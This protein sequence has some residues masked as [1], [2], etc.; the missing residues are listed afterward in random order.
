MGFYARTAVVAVCVLASA[1]VTGFSRRCRRRC[2]PDAAGADEPAVVRPGRQTKAR[3]QN[4]DVAILGDYAFV[5]G[6]SKN[7]GALSTPGRIC[8]DYGG[9]KVVEHR[10]SRC[11]DGRRQIDIADTKTILTGPKGNPRRTANV[12]N[13]SST[14]SSVD[15]FHNPVTNKDI[16]AIT[17]ERCEQSFFDGARI[18]FWDVTN[19]NGIPSTPIGVMDP[20]NIINPACIPGPCP[21]NTPADG[22]WGIFEDIRMFSRNNGPGGSTKVYAIATSPFSIG[23]TGGVS[24]V[25][26]FRLLDVTNPANPS[27]SRASPTRRSGRARTTAAAPSRPRAPRRR[28][29]TGRARSC[30]T[31]TARRRPAPRPEHRRAAAD[32]VRQ[33]ELGRAVQLRPRQHP[34]DQSGVGTNVDPKI[35]A[36]NPAVFGYPPAAD[37]GET[38]RGPGRGQRGG[39]AGLHRPERRDPRD[40]VRGGQRSRAHAADDRRARR[41]AHTSRGCAMLGDA[42]KIYNRP[43]QAL[44]ATS[45]TSAAAARRRRSST[46]R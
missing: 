23:N 5:A 38:R 40:R 1:C 7:H 16:L 32:A 29:R 43:A 28:R 2:R 21:P 19:P 46:A 14:A 44:S 37:G 30:R 41:A 31:T 24:F 15:V 3:G 33:H 45:P 13:V 12:K 22:R 8:T 11:A 35:F 25:G 39:R 36:P 18:E 17:T 27:S 42:T 4:G 26:D 6:G 34:D 10:Q 9:V 20:E